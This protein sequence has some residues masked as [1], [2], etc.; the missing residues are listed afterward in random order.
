M[1]K[2]IYLVLCIVLLSVGCQSVKKEFVNSNLWGVVYNMEGQ[3]ISEVSVYQVVNDK[4]KLRAISD[5]EG[6]FIL[7]RISYGKHTFIF[8]SEGY[9]PYESEIY[10]SRKGQILYARLYNYYQLR[11]ALEEAL[12][13]KD[14]EKKATEF[15]ER[16]SK[17]PESSEEEIRYYQAIIFFQQEEYEKSIEILETLTNTKDAVYVYLFLADIYEWNLGDDIKAKE[18]LELAYNH[19]FVNAIE[20]HKIE[21]RLKDLSKE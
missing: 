8:E 20:K 10:F 12:E 11:N 16:L 5:V 13:S 18:N 15:L 17:M 7:Q 21:K 14:L 4:K 9:E 1:N 19:R 2:K 3:A 6:R